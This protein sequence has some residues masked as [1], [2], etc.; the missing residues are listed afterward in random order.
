MVCE[1][2]PLRPETFYLI[3]KSGALTDFE[4]LCHYFRDVGSVVP[5]VEV[6]V[7]LC[8]GGDNRVIKGHL[9]EADA[10][11]KLC[12]KAF[13]NASKRL[14]TFETTNRMPEN[15]RP[16]LDPIIAKVDEMKA[17]SLNGENVFSKALETLSD[18]KLQ[19]LSAIFEKSSGA[20]TEDKL[21]KAS[22]TFLEELSILDES[23]EQIRKVQHSIIS[24]FIETFAIK[25]HCL[26]S[27]EMV[28]NNARFANEV[29]ETVVYRRGL[30]RASQSQNAQEETGN[31]DESRGCLIM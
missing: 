19:E 24:S 22:Y 2:L 27:G 20:F 11:K 14:P 30:R 8:G 13:A 3:Y 21:I 28:F 18:E 4:L 9:K 1:R 7:R 23:V 26:R 29:A 16:F 25:Y 5:R 10:V 15:L 12:K 31:N 6:G 17:Q